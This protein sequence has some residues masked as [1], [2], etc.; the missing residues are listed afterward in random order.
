[1]ENRITPRYLLPENEK[2]LGEGGRRLLSS[3]SAT[4][5]P[6][7]LISLVTVVLN[8][9]AHLEKTLESVTTQLGEHAEYIVIDGGSTDRTLDIIRKYESELEY[10]VSEP[11]LGISD[12]FNKGIALCRGRVVGVLN[13]GDWYEGQAFDLV[14]KFFHEDN[15][16]GVLCG[17]LQYWLGDKKAYISESRPEL[18]GREMSVTHPTCFIQR[19]VYLSH[20]GFDPTYK[21]AMDYELLLRFHVQ[22]V[23]FRCIPQIL[24]HMLHE[25]VSEKNWRKALQETWRARRKYVPGSFF[26]GR[27]YFWYLIGRKY[28]R[29]LLQRLGL[30][31]AVR[32]YRERLAPVRKR[33]PE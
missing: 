6:V 26:A 30:H 14:E 2:R 8:D 13:S 33:L 23:V 22:G 24:A 1:M 7:P 29:F 31:G 5:R 25:G 15:D 21:Y 10:W 12:G 20:G 32:F 18:L 16:T 4:E 19:E 11:D 17:S 9:E 3:D 28:F 27:L